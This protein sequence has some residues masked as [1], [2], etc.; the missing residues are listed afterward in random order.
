MVKRED[1]LNTKVD[2]F[3]CSI[4]SGTVWYTNTLKY[5]LTKSSIKYKDKIFH[6]RELNK[7]DEKKAKEYKLNNLLA[8]TISAIFDNYR[9]LRCIKEKTGFITIDIDKDKNPDMDIN[10]AKQDVIRLPYVALTMLS[11][12][13]EGIWCLIP[14]NKENDFKET[15][16]ALYDDFKEIGYVIDKCKDET[17]LRIVSYDD[18][19]L[20]KGNTEEYNKI[21]KIERYNVESDYDEN[22]PD[23]ELT[24]T[25]LI[26]LTKVIY[27]LV[28]KHNYTSDD[29]DEWLLDGFRLATIPNKEVG[30]KL[31]TLISE[32]S[33]NFKSYDDVREKFEECCRTTTYR[34]NILGFYINK[35]KEYYGNEWRDKIKEL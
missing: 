12:R 23:W 2:V 4:E 6:V 25:D 28:T 5:F 9:A 10:K 31:F 30:L 18:N 7:I 22:T 17:R 33:D 3:K 21:K 35:I 16:N 19:I 14:Y 27:L 15:W 1:I 32:N 29:Y 20:I 26:E 13:G 34:T 11:C 8:C 24:K